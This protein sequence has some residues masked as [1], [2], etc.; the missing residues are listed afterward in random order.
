M[1]NM[2]AAYRLAVA[3]GVS[4]PPARE[5]PP[6]PQEF[7]DLADARARASFMSTLEPEA[8]AAGCFMYDSTD[9][10]AIATSAPLVASYVDG[11]GGYTAAVARFGAAK[12]VSI[13]VGNNPAMVA[14]VEPGAMTAS[15]LPGWIAAQKARGVTRPGLYS[16]GSQYSSVL[17]AGGSSCS[18]WTA[19]PTGV[20]VQTLPGRDAVQSAFGSTEDTSWCLPTWPWFPGG[21]GT[22]P[23]PPPPASTWPL[24]QGSTDTADVTTMQTNINRWASVIGLSPVLTVDGNFGPLTAAAVS[25]AETHFGMAANSQCSEAL[26]NDL[27]GTPGGTTPPPPPP[28]PPGGSVVIDGFTVGKPTS[29]EVPAVVAWNGA[30]GIVT[31]LGTIPMTAWSQITWSTVNPN[32]APTPLP[33]PVP[34]P[35]SSGYVNPLRSITG[36]TPERI[37]QGVDYAG[38]GPLYSL[39]NGTVLNV[40]NSG[41]PGGTFITVRLSDGPASGKIF[42]FA[43]NITPQVSVGQQVTTSTV[44]G[45][46]INAF[47]N[48]ELGW[49]AEPGN[50]ESLARANGQISAAGDPGEV[51]SAY[52]KNFSDLLVSLGA[53]AGILQSSGVVGT[54]AAGWPAW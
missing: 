51:S 22:T 50:G 42:Y 14:D 47:P 24:V 25:L 20:L 54:L 12:V 2:M 19:N 37:D 18:Y 6:V 52:G 46:L 7:I 8:T 29:T 34:T 30:D 15:E 21:G 16:D 5:A 35:T 31:R 32:P 53:P 33:A 41:W 26:F 39:G 9:P 28:P 38:A 3:A 44:L 23:P 4:L 10:S 40:T 11:Y 43:E 1:T 27:K 36:L 17:A 48:C 49:A 45:T 13:S